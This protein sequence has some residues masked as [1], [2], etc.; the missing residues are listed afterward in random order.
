MNKL[1]LSAFAVSL[2]SLSTQ[3]LAKSQTSENFFEIESEL[4]PELTGDQR[5]TSPDL[6]QDESWKVRSEEVVIDLP[7]PN[8]GQGYSIIPWSD[9]DAQDWLSYDQWQIERRFKDVTPDWKIRLREASHTELMGKVL[10]CRGTCSIYRG[11]NKS[12]AQYLSQVLEGDEFKTGPD[13]V[14]WIYLLDGSLLRLS[15]ET[16]VSLQE[17]NFSKNQI[18]VVTRLN[19]GH[20]F[21]HPRQKN[22]F[23][24][25]S[26]PETDS[27]SLPLMVREANQQFFERQIFK[28]QNDQERTSEVMVLDERAMELQFKVLNEIKKENDLA[29]TIP[30]KLIMVSPNGTLIT[31]GPSFD[32]VHLAGSESFFKKRAT[33]QG[34]V[35][36]L[37]LRGYTNSGV[38]EITENHWFRIEA[39][40]KVF[41]RL[42]N[43]SGPLEILELLTRRIKSIELA[44]EIWTRDFTIPVMK[45]L[46][47]PESLAKDHGYTLWGEEL[48]KRF[49]FL[50]EYTRRIETTN[51]RS[52]E[53]LFTKRQ[54][55]GRV[56]K[57]EL[58]DDHY[59]KSLN[60]YLLGLKSRYDK[61]KMNVREM[62]ELKYYVWILK[63]GKV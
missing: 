10:R 41:T 31:Q 13:S 40:G 14:A 25:D 15:S 12:N 24:P 17:M 16:S 18:L 4:L 48:E 53:N 7:V 59:R 47:S 36:N 27:F 43:P 39:D 21:W 61:N 55:F 6:H 20:V 28:N 19:E 51:L 49:N 50:V 9:L 62:S 38:F 1:I 56:M 63:N 11:A 37:H 26:G 34:D 45:S 32:M 57:K 22:E 35:F 5:F 3:I 60:H 33:T 23:L 42:D 52:I 44:R 58:S 8:K 46:S 54:T 29:V 2:I 30:T